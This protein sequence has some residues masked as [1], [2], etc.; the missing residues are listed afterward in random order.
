MA[1]PHYTL[2]SNAGARRSTG[3][4][5]RHTR[6]RDGA[7]SAH[8]RG[9]AI[10]CTSRASQP[11]HWCWLGRAEHDNDHWRSRKLPRTFTLT[12]CKM[13]TNVL[14]FLRLETR[15]SFNGR[16]MRVTAA[17]SSSSHTS[18]D[19]LLAMRSTHTTR[20]GHSSLHSE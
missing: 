11:C 19:A 12:P 10:F 17:Y 3:R 13:L 15:A 6:P 16:I 20:L 18:P 1:A 4:T 14:R 7:S 9:I 2:S 8:D 5:V